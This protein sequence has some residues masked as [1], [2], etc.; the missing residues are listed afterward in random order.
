MLMIFLLLVGA[1]SG[2]KRKQNSSFKQAKQQSKQQKE[3]TNSTVI[4]KSCQQMLAR[5]LG[6]P[7]IAFTRKLPLDSIVKS[8]Y[9]EIL[10]NKIIVSSRDIR[11][12]V[13]RAMLLTNSYCLSKSHDFIPHAIF[14]QQY[15]YSVRQLVNG[16]KITNSANT[17]L[18]LTSYWDA[19]K[20][21]N[22]TCKELETCY[23]N[24]IVEQRLLYFLNTNCRI[25][26]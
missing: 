4:C 26:S 14:T 25:Y 1:S 24:H 8:D 2:T 21:T 16:K 13:S 5:N 22:P 3:R 6:F 15:W 11:N 12:I 20:D 23:N 10:K 9:R 7:Y 19:F 18:D 17:S